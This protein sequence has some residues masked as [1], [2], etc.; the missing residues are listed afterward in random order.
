MG[1]YTVCISTDPSP[2]TSNE[3]QNEERKNSHVIISA[4]PLADKLFVRRSRYAIN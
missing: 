4:P 1:V 2:K 3:K